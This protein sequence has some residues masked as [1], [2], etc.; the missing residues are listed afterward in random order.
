MNTSVIS[1]PY[2]ALAKNLASL[3]MYAHE[4]G[5]AAGEGSGQRQPIPLVPENGSYRTL[6]KYDLAKDC[7]SIERQWKPDDAF[8]AKVQDGSVIWNSTTPGNT[9]PNDWIVSIE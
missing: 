1:I 4:F 2:A 7:I 9:D 6:L 3:T 5:T 8:L